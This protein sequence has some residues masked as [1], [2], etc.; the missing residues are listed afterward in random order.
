MNVRNLNDFILI[1]KRFEQKPQVYETGILFEAIAKFNANNPNWHTDQLSLDFQTT[2][3]KQRI[4]EWFLT[5]NTEKLL[6]YA[7]H[8]NG[9]KFQ[10]L[11]A[12]IRGFRRTFMAQAAIVC[13]RKKIKRTRTCLILFPELGIGGAERALVLLANQL[14]KSGKTVDVYLFK[15][16]P[17]LAFAGSLNPS[18]RV[19]GFA[20]MVRTSYEATINYAHWVTPEYMFSWC[21]SERYIQYIHNDL[22]SVFGLYPRNK[23]ERWYKKTDVII[24][25]SEGVKKSFI[26]LFPF[27]QDKAITIN[28]PYDF[29]LLNPYLRKENDRDVKASTIRIISVSRL[30]EAKGI[31]RCLQVARRLKDRNIDFVWEFIGQGD[32]EQSIF[33]EHERL[34]LGE[35]VIFSGSLEN[36]FK[37]VSDCDI[38][39]LASFYE[40]YGLSAL[41]AKYIGVPVIIT[42]F[43]SATEV[44]KDGIDGLIVKNTIDGIESGLLRLIEDENLRRSIVSNAPNARK[45]ILDNNAMSINKILSAISVPNKLQKES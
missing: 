38:F 17:K 2:Q 23:H 33:S 18:I 12:K 3:R 22:C 13:A 39:V 1:L 45:E 25:V 35:S 42:E 28:N 36:P 15:T 40:G 27:A 30:V 4:V 7:K 43:C 21:H 9:I 24:C 14:V 34:S 32:D 41:E 44:V 20:E 31:R 37:R 8:H 26:K 5:E 29:T 6:N 16:N 10:T 11:K 19:V